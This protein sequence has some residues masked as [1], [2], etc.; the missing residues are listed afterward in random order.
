[1]VKSIQRFSQNEYNR[2]LGEHSAKSKKLTQTECEDILISHGVSYE[3]A[4][5]G[6]Y[7]YIHHDGNAKGNK[8][9]SHTE[10][11]ELLNKFEA[12]Q[13]TP[14]ECIGYLESLG[15]SYRQSQTA[16]YK[17]RCRKGLIGK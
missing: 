9:G 5:N 17:Y 16:V 14:K 10:Y 7:V 2:V 1:M 3:Q 8:R 12:T 4:K 15:F 11:T 6:A 13:K